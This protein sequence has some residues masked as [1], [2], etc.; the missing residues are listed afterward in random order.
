MASRVETVIII[1][2][3]QKPRIAA[4]TT[5][6]LKSTDGGWKAVSSHRSASLFLC[7]QSGVIALEKER[8]ATVV[9][10]RYR[11]EGYAALPSGPAREALK[12][13]SRRD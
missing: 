1:H 13:S 9:G 6:V 11:L 8:E 7:R 5:S 4:V 12:S 3:S 2:N 10:A